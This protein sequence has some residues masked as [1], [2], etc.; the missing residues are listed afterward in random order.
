M[1][2]MRFTD[3]VSL[4]RGL[5]LVVII[6][7]STQGQLKAMVQVANKSTSSEQDLKSQQV[8]V[9]L[10]G[11]AL[12]RGRIVKETGQQVFIDIGPTIVSL[13]KNSIGSMNV[14]SSDKISEE[15]MSTGSVY[16][17]G[18]GIVFKHKD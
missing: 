15:E 3:F 12:V 14:V 1:K 2:H 5:A 9:K 4:S 10:V 6:L 16:S 7:V 8:E 18:K 11:G 17:T 13:P